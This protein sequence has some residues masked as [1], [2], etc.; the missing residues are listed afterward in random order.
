MPPQLS[1]PASKKPALAGHLPAGLSAALKASTKTGSPSAIICY[2]RTKLA[3][4]RQ[5]T[6]SKGQSARPHR[7]CRSQAIPLSPYRAC[8]PHVP[9]GGSGYRGTRPRFGEDQ[10]RLRSPQFRAELL[11]FAEGGIAR[12]L[13]Q[14]RALSLVPATLMS[15]LSATTIGAR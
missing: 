14:R 12:N 7:F 13:R 15:R 8:P 2:R 3:T 6:I 5:Y 10:P 11:E 1:R 4:L 9:V